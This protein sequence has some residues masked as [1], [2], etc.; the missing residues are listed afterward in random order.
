MNYLCM[1]IFGIPTKVAGLVHNNLHLR[2]YNFVWNEFF[3]DQN[4]QNS[5]VVDKDDGPD[6]PTDYVLLRRGKRH[7]YFTSC[8]PFAQKGTSVP[9]PIGSTAPVY[10]NG[11][12]LG[13]TQGTTNYGLAINATPQMQGFVG[14]YN[15]N[16]GSAAAGASI[17]GNQAVGVVPSPL[18]SGLVADLSDLDIL[19]QIRDANP[20]SQLPILWSEDKDP[21]TDWD[22]VMWN[23]EKVRVV[24]LNINNANVT[25]LI[26]V[27][28]L[29]LLQYLYC[30]SNQLTELNVTGLTSLQALSC[31][32]NQLTSLNVTGLTA[33]QQLYCYY[34]QLTTLNVD[35]LTALQQ[36]DCYYN[37]LT[38][39]NVTGL[40]ALRRLSSNI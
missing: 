23:D 21:Y 9:I 4:L 40:T 37:Q 34:N 39:L 10:G 14:N 17:A 8:L 12:A 36:L 28:K 25:T 13:L 26:N 7:D 6:T 19:R 1:I 38:T 20:D 3:R 16:V 5:V 35:G 24:E 31:S 18:G 32:S 33:L 29:T 11:K 15:S 2:A 30:Y 22:G 27:N